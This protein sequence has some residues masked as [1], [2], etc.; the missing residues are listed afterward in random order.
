MKNKK[1]QVVLNKISEAIEILRNSLSTLS[2][3]DSFKIVFVLMA[4]KRF[5]DILEQ[6]GASNKSIITIPES[7]RWSRLDFSS[8]QLFK[9]IDKNLREISSANKGLEDIAEALGIQRYQ[10]NISPLTQKE[11][12]NTF[13]SLDLSLNNFSLK[14]FVETVSVFFEQHAES[15]GTRSRTAHTPNSLCKL[16]VKLLNPQISEQI[17][18]PF[19]GFGDTLISAITHIYENYRWPNECEQYNLSKNIDIYDED[20]ELLTLTKLRLAMAGVLNNS[21]RKRGPLTDFNIEDKTDVVFLKPPF[22]LF[23]EIGDKPKKISF[24]SISMGIS[25]IGL[26]DNGRMGI[27]LPQSYFLNE[28]KIKFVRGFFDEKD[29]IEAII[30]LPER[31]FPQTSLSIN[32][33][34]LNENK[35]KER[36]HKVIFIKVIPFIRDESVSI[37][38]EEIERIVAVYKNFEAKTEN[39]EIVTYEEIQQNNFNLFPN[40]YV[41]TFPREIKE[42]RKNRAAIP[43][44]DICKIKRGETRKHPYKD[45]DGLPFIKPLDLPTDAMHPYIDFN[46]V[47]YVK[48]SSEIQIIRHKCILVS[49]VGDILR[50]TIFDP[51]SFYKKESVKDDKK[52]S[53]ILVSSNIAVIVPNEDKVDFEYLFYQ[54]YSPIVKNQHEMR[55]T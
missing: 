23:V 5:N 3:F 7:S 34:I 18:D 37:S 47:S 55:Y 40:C 51:N 53:E 19:C 21:T 43:L 24:E 41:G 33:L 20:K 15:I 54:L 29:N 11:L 49:L 31:L 28:R 46:N 35:P 52:Y 32:L 44:K 10:P 42:L 4:Y 36:K 39:E 2:S 16:L 6:N 25:F 50:P 13:D 14:E 30:Q 48:P 9:Q 26:S 38:D 12:L 1:T 17:Y 22:N 45:K 8:E 27:V